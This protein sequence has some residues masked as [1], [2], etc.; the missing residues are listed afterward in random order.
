MQQC[1]GERLPH[2]YR[3]DRP[4]LLTNHLPATSEMPMEACS[5]ALEIYWAMR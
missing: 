4:S 5:S 3:A 1:A 2:W